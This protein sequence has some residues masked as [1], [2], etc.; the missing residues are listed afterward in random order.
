MRRLLKEHK[1]QVQMVI[2]GYVDLAVTKRFRPED[3]T[4]GQR[5]PLSR[6]PP[7]FPLSH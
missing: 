2:Y 1:V 7:L 3:Q 4:D 6:K 5:C